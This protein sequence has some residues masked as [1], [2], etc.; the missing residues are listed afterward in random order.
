[1]ANAP[2]VVVPGPSRVPLPYGLLSVLGDQLRTSPDPHVLG[3]IRWES[4][5]GDAASTWNPCAT[6]S[7]T[8]S[9]AAPAKTETAERVWH[10][11]TPFTIYAELVCSP[12]DFYERANDLAEEAL[13]LTEESAVEAVFWTGTV[14]GVANGQYPHLMAATAVTEGAPSSMVQL[15]FATTAVTG[16][17]VDV[18]RGLGLLEAALADCLDTVGYI[19]VDELTLEVMAANWLV[20]L[21]N[22]RWVTN[23]G[24]TVVVGGGYPAQIG[25]DGT[26]LPS[27]Q[28]WMVATGPIVAYRGP[29][30]VNPAPSTLTRTVDTVT[31]IAER[32]YVIGFD[33]CLYAVRV[34]VAATVV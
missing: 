15:Q 6:E 1:V 30:R 18:T 20:T 34:S 10:G 8:V 31:A 27:T 24:H 32:T 3:G 19:H 17:V 11:A 16:T 4:V 9:G 23:A 2:R 7:P 22:G 12:V 5:C 29:V 13:S 14:A 21:R 33:C 26:S 28:R 25:P